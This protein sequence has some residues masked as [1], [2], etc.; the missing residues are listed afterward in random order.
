MFRGYSFDQLSEFGFEEMLHLL[1]WGKIP[2]VEQTEELRA[3]IAEL[4]CNIPPCV[5][6]VIRAFP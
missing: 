6:S 2:T 4:I 1:V 5:F 3:Q